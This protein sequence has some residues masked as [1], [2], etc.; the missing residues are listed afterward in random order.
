MFY[1]P[2][3]GEDELK[4]KLFAKSQGFNG[5]IMVVAVSDLHVNSTIGLCP[6]SVQL[7][8][9]G[10][11]T[12]SKPQRVLW[13]AWLDFCEKAHS[14][15]I[16]VYVILNGD[17]VEADGFKSLQYV[18][19]N[20][21]TIHDMAMTVLAPL[22]DKAKKVFVVRG[23]EYHVGQSSPSE[24]KIAKDLLNIVPY[25]KKGT[26]SWW[27]LRTKIAG[28]SFDVAHHVSMGYMPWTEKNAANRIAVQLM[29]EYAEWGEPYPQIALRAHMHRLSDS[30]LNFPIHAFVMPCWCM[31]SAFT[32]RIGRGNDMPKIGGLIIT[33]EKGKAD[34]EAIM[35]KPYRD[36][37]RTE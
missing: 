22:T 29:Y 28:V 13:E 37:V 23:T 33:C 2:T 15:K 18:S 7:D 8:D 21:S 9:G 14:T 12:P 17:L 31:K 26:Y 20:T 4:N 3:K 6:P 27:Y 32:H 25:D 16:P 5:K 24:E 30:G 36:D 10:M 35:Y 34:V 19:K 11:Y 1:P